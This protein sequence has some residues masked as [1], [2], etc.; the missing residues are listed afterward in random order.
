MEEEDELTDDNILS[1]KE[2]KNSSVTKFQ[3]PIPFLRQLRNLIFGKHLPDMFTRITFYINSVLWTTFIIWH[4]LSYVT[5]TSRD[6]FLQQKGLP[7]ESIV[8]KRGAELGFEAGEFLARLITFHGIAIIC[9]A[10]MFIGL[11]FLYRKFKSFI[12]VI[13]GPVVFYIGMN[14]FYVG[15]TYF[16]DDTT[17]YDKVAL[18]IIIVN[19]LLHSYLIKN[20]RD[21]DGH[22]SFFGLGSQE[23]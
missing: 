9:W 2:S 21:E 7:I 3:S 1:E 4:I 15:F 8:E 14:I 11:I 18:L 12:Y 17:M 13:L 19:T 22:V 10:I 23:G 5:L 6:L 16:M 20:G